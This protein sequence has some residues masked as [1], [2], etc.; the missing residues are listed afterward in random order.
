MTGY[1]YYRLL[2]ASDPTA[3]QLERLGHIAARALIDLVG[4]RH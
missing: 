2:T 3:S 4:V 1:E